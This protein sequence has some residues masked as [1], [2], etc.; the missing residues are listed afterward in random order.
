MKLGDLSPAEAAARLAGG[1]CSL[2]FGPFVLRA[3]TN[4]G[5]VAAFAHHIYA[6]HEVVDDEF[7][8][9]TITVHSS[10]DPTRPW[11]RKA[12]MYL[13][14]APFT[15]S[16]SAHLGGPMLEWGL[17]WV[18]ASRAHAYLQIHAGAVERNG[19]AVILPATSGSGKSTLCANLISA[20]WRLFSDEFAVIAP[21]TGEVVPMPRGVSLKNASIAVAQRRHPAEEFS[22][23][24]RNTPK[25]DISILRAPRSAIERAAERRPP[26]AVVFPKWT[27]GAELAVT[28]V[29]RAQ[30]LTRLVHNSI[31]YTALGELGF[32]TMVRLVESVPIHDL[33]YSDTSPVLDWFERLAGDFR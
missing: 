5:D 9:A 15:T 6:N 26:G 8:D 27:A 1:G 28:P 3:Q 2:R 19:R 4:D 13:D 12:R 25:G 23:T 18:I 29:P 7:A 17:N 21:E 14:G 24:F 32:Q 31:N 20:G 11:H 30:A 16:M 22:L 10:W 33:V